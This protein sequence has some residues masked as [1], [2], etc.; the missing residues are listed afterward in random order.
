MLFGHDFL[1]ISLTQIYGAKLKLNIL[2][3]QS[4]AE[5]YIERKIYYLSGWDKALKFKLDLGV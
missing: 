5:V 2:F 4:T 1:G 3:Y